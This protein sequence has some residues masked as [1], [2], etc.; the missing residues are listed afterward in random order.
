MGI[1]SVD[2][3]LGTTSVRVKT[4][5]ESRCKNQTSLWESIFRAAPEQAE[6]RNVWFSLQRRAGKMQLSKVPLTTHP[7]IL[8]SPCLG[9][10]YPRQRNGNLKQLIYLF[11]QA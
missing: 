11:C 2:A 6:D 10:S 9:K 4:A 7:E 3:G 1:L 5:L 8:S